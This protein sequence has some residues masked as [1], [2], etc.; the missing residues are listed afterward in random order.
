MTVRYS[1]LSPDSLQD[2]VDR[3]V[4]LQSEEQQPNRTDT[5]TETNAVASLKSQSESVH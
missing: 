4:P 3:L 2:A 5:T 1:H